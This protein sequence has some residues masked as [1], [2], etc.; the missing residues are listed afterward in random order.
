MGIDKKTL[1]INVR[2]PEVERGRPVRSLCIGHR[3]LMAF[4]IK[5][6]QNITEPRVER[7]MSRWV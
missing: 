5:N 3:L 4:R 7:V 1:F 6:P 2:I